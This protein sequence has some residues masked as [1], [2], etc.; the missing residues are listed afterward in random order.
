MKK[1]ILLYN[2]PATPMEEMTQEQ[3]EKANEG[4]RVWMDKNKDAIVDIGSPMAAGRAVADDGSERDAT[5]INGYTI[6]Q[7]D[8]MSGA[9]ATAEDHPF[10]SDK[11]GAFSIEVYELLPMSM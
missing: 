1:F 4:W 7:A 3:G 8:D 9:L 10:L 2:G 6:V 5:P 11:A